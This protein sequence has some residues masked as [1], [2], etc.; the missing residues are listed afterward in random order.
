[1]INSIKFAGLALILAFLS[2]CSEYY[3]E[4][5]RDFICDERPRACNNTVPMTTATRYAPPTSVSICLRA[6]NKTAPPKPKPIPKPAPIIIIP[7]AQTTTT[8]APTTTTTQTTTVVPPLQTS[9]VQ[10]R[11]GC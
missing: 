6:N 2:A 1:M 3:P 11:P 9:T 8:V 5:D 7:P 10:P 4:D